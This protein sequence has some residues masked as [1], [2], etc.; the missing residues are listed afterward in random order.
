MI[1][2]ILAALGSAIFAAVV[3]ICFKKVPY[4][5]PASYV[6]ILRSTFALI[7]F[8]IFSIPFINPIEI[9][10]AINV[11]PGLA[12]AIFI[13]MAIG[14]TC[15]IQSLK[16]IKVSRATAIASIYPLFITAW[17]YLLRE[18]I[19]WN[20]L[21]GALLMI[22]AVWIASKEKAL[23]SK[24]NVANENIIKGTIF[25]LLTALFWAIGIS[26]VRIFID[27]VNVMLI[28][29]MRYPFVIVPLLL[30]NLLT[31]RKIKDLICLPKRV[32]LFTFLAGL[33]TVFSNGL[34]CLSLQLMEASL[35]SP[36][37]SS[38]PVLTTLLAVI[39]LK[40]K[41]TISIIVS[42]A[43]VS[44]SIWVLSI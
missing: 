42:V 28:N 23:V 29:A 11:L 10:K 21:L 34:L 43:L 19:T 25:A 40:E 38:Q 37:F 41:P 30:Y 15:Y 4:S 22:L 16:Y 17:C 12:L 24:D 33:F 8:W 18:E 2:G 31:K 1:L 14:D 35:A 9:H 32:Y 3:S 5:I 20:K 36:I 6:N 7:L 26:L 27:E 39:I 13:G 44:F